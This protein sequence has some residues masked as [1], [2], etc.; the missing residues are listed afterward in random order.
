MAGKAQGQGKGSPGIHRSGQVALFCD[1]LL[2]SCFKSHFFGGQLFQVI[3]FDSNLESLN[4]SSR[5]PKDYL[6]R[7][8]LTFSFV[9]MP[10]TQFHRWGTESGISTPE[11]FPD[12][13][14]GYCH[15]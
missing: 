2:F 5:I 7:A 8:S 15:P 13:C 11:A 14:G 6:L 9:P 3:V 4:T 10:Q 1:F 12:L